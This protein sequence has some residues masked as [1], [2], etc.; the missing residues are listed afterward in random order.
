M[1]HEL[2]LPVIKFDSK[3]GKSYFFPDDGGNSISSGR[4]FESLITPCLQW[5]TTF[6]G[7][8]DDVPFKKIS[9]PKYLHPSAV[10]MD[11]DNNS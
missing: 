2:G 10:V 4:S 7:R 9:L 8:T 11:L 1:Y 6:H 5:Y 3:Q